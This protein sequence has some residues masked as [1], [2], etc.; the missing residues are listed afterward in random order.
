MMDLRNK[1]E[2][3][4]NDI[5]KFIKLNNICEEFTGLLYDIIYV[6]LLNNKVEI[7]TFDVKED[8]FLIEVEN[9]LDLQDLTLILNND[10]EW[11][12]I[13]KINHNMVCFDNLKMARNYLIKNK[14][15]L[16]IVN[17]K[18]QVINKVEENLLKGL[19]GIVFGLIIK[20]LR[21]E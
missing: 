12:E 3:I 15:I 8:T 6:E 7:K 18:F 4:L 10:E 20:N 1:T 14:D 13:K 21:S 9:K 11:L 17:G 16:L 5:E 19:L 2:D